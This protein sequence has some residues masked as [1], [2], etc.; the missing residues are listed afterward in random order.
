M[1]VVSVTNKRYV[2]ACKPKKA[3]KGG[4]TSTQDFHL[5][6][7]YIWV[8]SNFWQSWAGEKS[9]FPHSTTVDWENYKDIF[10]SRFAW[11]LFLRNLPLLLSSLSILGA[12]FQWWE[13]DGRSE[14][15]GSKIFYCFFVVV[16]VLYTAA[17]VDCFP[18]AQ[19]TSRAMLGVGPAFQLLTD[20]RRCRFDTLGKFKLCP[21]CRSTHHS[22]SVLPYSGWTCYSGE[23]TI[24]LTHSLGAHPPLTSGGCSCT[25][26]RVQFPHTYKPSSLLCPY[27]ADTS[28]LA[29]LSLV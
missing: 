14:L 22:V 5:I 29:T 11:F 19:R 4:W 12:A 3:P 16:V 27:I 24:G 7:E 10:V 17:V 8:F 18:R 9:P 28:A 25:V 23:Q 20:V 1:S 2:W 15:D 13:P 26:G 6:F 21:P